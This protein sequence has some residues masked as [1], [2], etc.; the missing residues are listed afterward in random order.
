MSHFTTLVLLEDVPEDIEEAVQE[1]LAPYD[2]NT[3]V[4]SYEDD[5]DCIGQ[6]ARNE[7]RQK[8]DEA[9][10][11]I[12]DLRKS[13]WKDRTRATTEEERDQEQREWQQHMAEY[14]QIEQ[15][16]FNTHPL[17]D[18]PDP[19]C[20]FYAGEYWEEQVRLGELESEKLGTRYEDGSGCGGTGKYMTTYNPKSKW[21][22]WVIGGR[23]QG[24]LDSD[25]DPIKDPRNYETCDLCNGTGQRTEWPPDTDQAWIDKCGGCN[26]CKGKGKRLKWTLEPHDYGNVA[27]VHALFHNGDGN[28]WFVPFAIVTPDGTWNEK[29]KMG[30]WGM[31]RDQRDDWKQQ[32]AAI[33]AQHKNCVAVLCDLHI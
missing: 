18:K 7:A 15:E 23:W 1:R 10:G 8:A 16:A 11:T 31:V 3:E 30:W 2:E 13:F 32:A 29:G 26:G 25:Y 14:N 5:C 33:L 9:C 28:P 22:W 24:M 20:G 4:E 17:K 19:T 12:E 21:D 6:I 27:P